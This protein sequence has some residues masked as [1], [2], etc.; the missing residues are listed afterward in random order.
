MAA[1]YAPQPLAPTVGQALTIGTAYTFTCR[2]SDPDGDLPTSG[3]I[4]LYFDGSGEST[5]ISAATVNGDEVSWT[6]TITAGTGN[7]TVQFRTT[8]GTTYGAWSTPRAFSAAPQPAAPAITAPADAGTV[9]TALYDVTLT[10]GATPDVVQV[11]ILDT[12]ATT[13]LYDTGS[14]PF[15]T[16]VAVAFPAETNG[17]SGIP[18]RARVRTAGVWSDYDTHLV[19]VDYPAVPTPTVTVDEVTESGGVVAHTITVGGLT[20]TG[21]QDSVDTIGLYRRPYGDTDEG[22]L[23]ADLVP[24]SPTHD[25]WTIAHRAIYQYR[26]IS[27]SDAGA[28]A[29]SAWVGDIVLISALAD[30]VQ[31]SAL[32]DPVLTGGTA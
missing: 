16:T 23:L 19:T 1:P 13:V 28:T 24:A 15:A 8:D 32:A 27:A 25:D 20:P 12:T 22:D 11:Q 6:V 26:A 10:H 14:L 21:G 31:T 7:W 17:Q 3:Q 18:V 30:T 5:T 9:S 2:H 29:A 4:S